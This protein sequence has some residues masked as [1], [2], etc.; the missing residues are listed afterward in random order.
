MRTAERGPSAHCAATCTSELVSRRASFLPNAAWIALC[1]A[2]LSATAAAQSGPVSFTGTEYATDGDPREVLC[3]DLDPDQDAFPDLLIACDSTGTIDLYFGLGD[4]TFSVPPVSLSAGAAPSTLAVAD[5]NQDTFPDILVGNANGGEI[6]VLYGKGQRQFSAADHHPVGSAIL[7]HASSADVGKWSGEELLATDLTGNKLRVVP[8]FPEIDYAGAAITGVGGSPIDLIARDLDLDGAVDVLVL[9]QGSNDVWVMRN[10]RPVSGASFTKALS[11]SVGPTPLS[12]AAGDLDQDGELDLAVVDGGDNTVR[13]FRGV[14]LSG[15]PAQTTYTVGGRTPWSVAIADVDLDG[16]QD[17]V[18]SDIGGLPGSVFAMLNDGTGALLPP[19]QVS[20]V[21]TW[22][23]HLISA[24]LDRDGRADFVTGNFFSGSITVLLNSEGLPAGTG[25]I[26]GRAVMGE[27][28]ES[29]GERVALRNVAIEIDPDPLGASVHTSDDGSFLLR[30][31]PAGTYQVH[32]RASFVE[33]ATQTVQEVMAYAGSPVFVAAGQ[34]TAKVDLRFPWPVIAQAGWEVLGNSGG[35]ATWDVLTGFFTLNPQAA[36]KQEK[37]IPAFFVFPMPKAADGFPLEGY[38]ASGASVEQ[39]SDN[40]Q[41]LGDW[42]DQRVDPV[43]AQ[44]VSSNDLAKVRYSFASSCMGA[45]ITRALISSG[46]LPE[47]QIN[48]IVSF[49]GVHGGT[50]FTWVPGLEELQLNG[51]EAPFGGAPGVSPPGWNTNNRD[52][53]GADTARWLCFSSSDELVRPELS[54]CGMGRVFQVPSCSCAAAG[55][56]CS[57]IPYCYWIDTWLSGSTAVVPGSHLT[58]AKDP[59]LVEQAAIFLDRGI[60]ELEAS[61]NLGCPQGVTDAEPPL[62]SAATHIPLDAHL[63]ATASGTVSVDGNSVLEFSALYSGE[64]ASLSVLAPDGAPA[65][66]SN[67]ITTAVGDGATLEEFQILQ[68]QIGDY[69]LVL[70][71][72]PEPAKAEITITFDNTQ[73]LLVST[74]P[75][76]PTLGQA[77]QV[78]ASFVGPTGNT[79]VP[80]SGTVT[81]KV[82]APDSAI[83]PLSLPLFDDGLH[84]DGL[85]GDGVFGNVVPGAFV[86]LDGH[87]PVKC[88]GSIVTTQGVTA[89]QG[90]TAFTVDPTSGVILG[91]SSEKAMDLNHNGKFEFLLIEVDVA[92][93]SDREMS[94]QG[95]FKD[96]AGALITQVQVAIPKGLGPLSQHAVDCV[97]SSDDLAKHGVDGPW[98][99][100]NIRLVDQDAGALT[101]STWPDYTTQAYSVAGFESLPGPRIQSLSKSSGHASGGDVLYLLGSGFDGAT[102]VRFGGSPAQFQV[103]TPN[104]IKVTVPALQPTPGHGTKPSLVSATAV[105]VTVATPSGVYTDPD[106]YTYLSRKLKN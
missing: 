90:D 3:A 27:S 4:G 80:S 89:R 29:S 52:L 39:H 21:G 46:R 76:S 101:C 54:S 45:L 51:A 104:S 65:T 94:L 58:L 105:D 99:L 57:T 71:A 22:P 63:Q 35:V 103:L 24:D 50:Q 13:I 64:G 85:A 30:G 62:M 10:N 34:T 5:V 79:T 87:Y 91:V 11:F 68:P 86:S 9:N 106:A 18:V 61:L 75:S 43:L 70:A 41:R 14:T 1:G 96:S 72:G 44:F 20:E 92:L 93:N 98:R 55:P 8:G 82:N 47:S 56:G 84:G 25:A 38:D 81:A 48:R 60:E 16:H 32:A 74:A 77:V 33:P 26:S 83:T 102:A 31:L 40:A 66:K 12:M 73:T 28:G 42:I 17:V 95:E 67:L 36:G 6:T 7:S 59:E 78:R 23:D 2:A 53:G 37:G 100:S 49:D 97:I 15:P 19:V 88:N 69:T